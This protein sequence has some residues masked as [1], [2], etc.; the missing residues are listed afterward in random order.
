MGNVSGQEF[1]DKALADDVDAIE[2]YLAKDPELLNWTDK[3]DSL[4]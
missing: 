2:V 1:K 4:F 3:V